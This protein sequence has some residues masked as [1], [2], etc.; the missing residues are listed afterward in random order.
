MCLVYDVV[1]KVII[2]PF[3]AQ[4]NLFIIATTIDDNRENNSH[5]TV[6]PHPPSPP[7]PL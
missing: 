1:N 2:F 7:L 6:L 4:E 3:H 5:N